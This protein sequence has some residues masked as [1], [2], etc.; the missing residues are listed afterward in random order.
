[1]SSANKKRRWL[2]PLLL[3][4]GFIVLVGGFGFYR[5][6]VS[7]MPSLEELE[8]YNPKLSTRIL[9]RNGVVIKELY[10]QRR[11]YVPLADISPHMTKAILAIEDHKFYHHWGMRPDALFFVVLK[12]VLLLRFHPRGASTITQQLAR[13]LY[14]SR[15][16]TIV[17]KLREQLTAIEI[18]RHY[19]KDEI[20]EMYLTQ[21]YFGHGAYGVDAAARAYFSCSASNLTVAQAA[22]IAGLPRS[23]SGY[24]PL[25][26]PEKAL[27]RRNVV[28]RRMWKLGFIDRRDYEETR[29]ND[30]GLLVTQSEEG[31]EGIAPY[32]TENVRQIVVQRVEALG[33]DPYHDGL[34]VETTLDARLQACAE[35]AAAEWMPTLQEQ[36]NKSYRSSEIYSLLR[37]LYPKATS[38]KLRSLARDKAL[39]DSL[40]KSELEVQLAFVAI[41]PATGGILAMIGGRDFAQTKFN[42]ATQAVRQ[43]GSAF[44]PFLYATVV[45]K[46]LPL[47]THVS[48]DEVVVKLP[49]GD[50][51]APKNYDGTS[52]GNL[53]LRDA[54]KK[55]LNLVSVRLMRDYTTPQEVVAM[56]RRLGLSTRIDP[57]DALALGSSGVI[58]LELVSAFGVFQARGIRADPLYVTSILDEFG[59]VVAEYSPQK[60]VVLSEQTAF[61]MTSLM[62]S[63]TREG[64]GAG[65]RSKFH[66]YQAAA[67]KTGTTNDFTDAWF[68]G[69]TPHLAAGV[70]VGFDNP[71]RTLGSG[72][73]GARAALPLW[74]RFI[75]F[76][77]DTMNYPD[78]K[79]SAPDGIITAE[80][81][82]ESGK[83]A[84]EGCPQT[85]TEYF[86]RKFPMEEHC[87]IH[88]G[89]SWPHRRWPSI[90]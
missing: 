20:L 78:R 16:R 10:T 6:L 47:S 3:G 70:W 44:K 87:P 68:V 69:F 30:L 54:L 50:I 2:L 72:Q 75:T 7:G 77:Y 82:A 9:D 79:F 40:L 67:G 90:L 28:L 45:D 66:F 17:R 46:G 42:R 65:L 11:F 73:D 62:E 37:Q 12:D 27:Q 39:V 26:Y 38:A 63:V 25:R 19:S 55:S 51:W 80:V 48:N 85:Y 83:L 74:A 71:S 57:V 52:G 15:E 59:Q 49:N 13:T 61:L 35:R 81:C 36:V 8:N 32:F 18:E 53:S 29:Q 14:F 41:D 24:D 21:S 1:M 22:L 64:T 76:A 56:A 33:I 31:G 86:D 60:S 43:P 58:P 34:T 5:Y 4:I 89:S 84:R 23:P 88:I